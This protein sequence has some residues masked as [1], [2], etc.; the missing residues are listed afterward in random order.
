MSTLVAALCLSVIT[1]LLWYS[2]YPWGHLIP[3]FAGVFIF[4]RG[5]RYLKFQVGIAKLLRVV[6]LAITA[7]IS[8]LSFLYFFFDSTGY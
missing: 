8:G 6:G 7:F 5:A 1:S 3:A 4:F 2:A